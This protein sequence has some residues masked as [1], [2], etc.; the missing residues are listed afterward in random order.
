MNWV[1]VVINFDMDWVVGKFGVCLDGVV[2]D[3]VVIFIWGR[4]YDNG[5][6]VSCDIM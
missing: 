1:V 6:E 2:L 4:V 3:V 5:V